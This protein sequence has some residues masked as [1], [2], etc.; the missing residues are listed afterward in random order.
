MSIKEI[1]LIKSFYTKQCF[2]SFLI[3]AY[4]RKLLVNGRDSVQVLQEKRSH[5]KFV[6]SA[7]AKEVKNSTIETCSNPRQPSRRC[8]GGQK[9]KASD[10]RFEGGTRQRGQKTNRLWSFLSCRT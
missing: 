6:T 10:D 2:C 1:R 5:L 7:T 4:Y 3:A 9:T 8:D